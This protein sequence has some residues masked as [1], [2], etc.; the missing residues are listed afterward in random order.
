VVESN[1]I[2]R[3]FIGL[4]AMLVVGLG[5]EAQVADIVRLP[6]SGEVKSPSP[7]EPRARVVPG[8]GLFM[9]FDM[10]GDGEVGAGE[11]QQGIEAA[12]KSADTNGNHALTALEQQAWAAQL[13]TRDTTL[14][15]PVRFDPNLDGRVTM[16]EF[17]REIMQLASDYSEGPG[18]TLKLA[19]LMIEG[20]DTPRSEDSPARESDTSARRERSRT[21]NSALGG[22]QNE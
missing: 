9:S 11:L 14:A 6:G 10:N 21:R 17:R 5:G 18:E 8:G 13:P 4:C 7:D 20:S 2:W 12:F 16:E 1:M 19:Q 22:L 3:G 15:N